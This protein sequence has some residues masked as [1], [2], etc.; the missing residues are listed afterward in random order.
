MKSNEICSFNENFD[1]HYTWNFNLSLSQYML[2]KTLIYKNHISNEIK[3][4]TIL[5]LKIT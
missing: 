5:Y 1:L 2:K 4:K 3:N